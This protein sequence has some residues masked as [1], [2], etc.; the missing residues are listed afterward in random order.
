MKKALFAVLMAAAL[1]LT[2]WSTYRA[3]M[4]AARVDVAGDAVYITVFG[5][6]DVYEIG[7]ETNG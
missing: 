5:R 7:G 1:L 2:A 4:R 6:T 3:N